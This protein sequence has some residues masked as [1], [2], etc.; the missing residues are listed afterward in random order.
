MLQRADSM[1]GRRLA[2]EFEGGVRSHDP[3]HR[4]R[5]R[6]A[7]LAAVARRARR[8]A[9]RHAADDFADLGRELEPEERAVLAQ[10]AHW[11]V[12]VFGD[13]PRDLGRRRGRRADRPAAAAGRRMGGSHRC[14][15]T[16]EATSSGSSRSGAGRVP[17]EDPLE[18]AALR[19]AFLR[20]DAV[21][22][23]GAAPAGL[24]R[25]RA[26]PRA[27]AHR[28][29]RRATRAHRVVRVRAWRSCT[30]GSSDPVARAGVRLRRVRLR[31]RVPR[32][33]KGAHHGRRRDLLPGILHVTPTSLDTWRR[34]PR[35][36]RNHHL[37][38]IPASD[39]HPGP[40]HGQ[41][42]H[43]VLRFVHEQGSCHDAAHVDDVLLAHG[44]DDNDRMRGETERAHRSVSR[45][46]RRRS[47]HEM[48]RARFSHHPTTPFMATA[49]IDALWVHDG[50][51]D[52]RD[53]K[54]GQ[55]WSDRVADDA[56]GAPPGV[57]PRA[58]RRG[59]R[60]PLRIAFEH[61]DAEV[62][63]DP[64]PFQP[65]ADDLARDRGSELRAEVPEIRSE[66]AFA[67][68]ADPDVCHRCSY[69]SICPDSVVAGVPIWPWSKRRTTNERI[70]RPHALVGRH[71]RLRALRERTP[72][73]SLLHHGRR[74]PAL[75]AALRARAGLLG[76]RAG[77]QHRA[78]RRGVHRRPSRSRSCSPRPTSRWCRCSRSWFR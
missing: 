19:V 71:P 17:D 59:A 23:R 34:C 69:R 72:L 64:E 57:G 12:H 76:R 62:V 41:Q 67:G 54:T 68:V 2:R 21:A 52:A 46:P 28:R 15:P 47:R 63:D 70:P 44:F 56:A 73:P 25:P 5:M 20:F 33:P 11:Y 51:L 29:T 14:A 48:T 38:G 60:P 6:D 66:T 7:F 18:L 53:Y 26:R 58:A 49:R 9:G 45:L 36:W 24:G 42:M 50:L 43:D 4:C 77:D 22:R 16:T 78:R 30:N 75:R 31:R 55:V 37:F 27:R 10:A 39:S 8:A 65:D 3:V 74:L 61:L 13:R 1:C 32:A 40:V 35:E